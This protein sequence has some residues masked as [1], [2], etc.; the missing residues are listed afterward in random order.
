M[1]NL[2]VKFVTNLLDGIS[3]AKELQR[4]SLNSKHISNR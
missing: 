3:E 1:W 4:K 2:M